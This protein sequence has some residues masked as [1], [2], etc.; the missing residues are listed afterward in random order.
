MTPFGIPMHE[1]SSLTKKPAV[2]RR[3]LTLDLVA[4]YNN[5]R[6][7]DVNSSVIHINYISY[8]T[9]Y[10]YFSYSVC[11][12]FSRATLDRLSQTSSLSAV[13]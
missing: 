7:P 3:G 13:Y 4:A 9:T 6:L 5:N 12:M 2:F 8:L 11:T 10:E 1:L